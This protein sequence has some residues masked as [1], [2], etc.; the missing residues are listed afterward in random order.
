[1]C[2]IFLSPEREIA[3]KFFSSLAGT[4][5]DIGGRDIKGHRDHTEGTCNACDRGRIEEALDAL[6]RF[7]TF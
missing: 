1:M 6:A 7:V 2:A 3:L 5:L 4:K